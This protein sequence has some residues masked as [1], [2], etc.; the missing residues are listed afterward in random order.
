MFSLRRPLLILTVLTLFGIQGWTQCTLSNLEMT[1]A[2]ISGNT[3]TFNLS[4][5]HI[6]NSGN[7]WV[8][9]HFWDQSEYPA[10]PYNYAVDGVPT[11][12]SL[13]GMDPQGTIVI[14]NSVVSATGN[15][16]Y[17]QAFNATYQ[18]DATFV[19]A[20]ASSST[21]SYDASTGKYL[22]THLSITFP[23]A[24]TTIK[25]DVWSSQADHNQTVA[26]FNTG[27]FPVVILPI[28]GIESFKAEKQSGGKLFFSWTSQTERNTDH[29]E[30]ARSTDATNWIS[31]AVLGSKHEDGYSDEPTC[32]N[33]TCD[34]TMVT[35]AGFA[36]IFAVLLIVSF[37]CRKYIPK[38]ALVLVVISSFGLSVACRKSGNP[39]GNKYLTT[40]YFQL[41]AV[42][43]DGHI[44]YSPILTLKL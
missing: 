8:T 7:K 15:Y 42:D 3:I 4:F 11:S 14:N 10:I 25:A 5:T 32:Y 29:Y 27:L 24:I 2:A 38:L 33:F 30:I 34:T 28:T 41:K 6:R 19:M 36:W 16:T 20:T 1:G 26:C 43:K 13:D 9:I 18:N 12:L 35:H 22:I 37:I 21:L 44:T 17:S 23:H 39:L 31:V 40:T